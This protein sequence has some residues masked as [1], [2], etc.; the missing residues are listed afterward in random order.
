MIHSYLFQASYMWLKADFYKRFFFLI[1]RHW[2]EK[3]GY[4]AKP[5]KEKW[6]YQTLT[7][8]C[9]TANKSTP[10]P[11]HKLFGH[12]QHVRNPKFVILTSRISRLYDIPYFK[13]CPIHDRFMVRVLLDWVMGKRRKLFFMK[14]HLALVDNA[15]TH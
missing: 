14:I 6:T 3:M 13:H 9:T 12:F 11:S 8:A 7:Q 5:E 1:Q 10:P 15:I 4:F 2:K